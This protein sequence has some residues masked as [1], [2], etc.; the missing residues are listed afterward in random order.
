MPIIDVGIAFAL[1]FADVLGLY[2]LVDDTLKA[3]KQAKSTQ[4]QV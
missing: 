3:K 1:S 2:L 4:V